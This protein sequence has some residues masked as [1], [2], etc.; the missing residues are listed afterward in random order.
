MRM[1]I[2]RILFRVLQKDVGREMKHFYLVPWS[3]GFACHT[4]KPQGH[5]IDV[6]ESS[7]YEEL[8]GQAKSLIPALKIAREDSCD[9][10]FQNVI[11]RWEAF[12]KSKG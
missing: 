1:E 7:E 5:S 3:V 10:Y 6:V 4:E 11:D 12:L 2:R 9:M 8:L